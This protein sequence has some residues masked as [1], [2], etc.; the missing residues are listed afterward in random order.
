MDPISPRASG[1][2][3]SFMPSAKRCN[4]LHGPSAL[5]RFLL[6][7]EETEIFKLSGKNRVRAGRERF[8]LSSL[9]YLLQCC[10]QNT[11]RCP[12]GLRISYTI[13][14]CTYSGHKAAY[15]M[16][17]ELRHQ[18]ALLSSLGFALSNNC[19]MIDIVLIV[20]LFAYTPRIF[21]RSPCCPHH[22][23]QNNA[24]FTYHSVVVTS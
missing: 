20:Q 3:G 17:P 1:P 23:P 6:E 12:I 24:H 9:S 8:S 10:G 5:R 21:L 13:I 2:C 4:W 16:A 18:S 15:L 11:V 7:D 22:Q 19:T 14:H